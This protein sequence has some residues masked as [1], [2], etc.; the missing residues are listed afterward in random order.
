[1]DCSQIFNLIL[2]S[3]CYQ[4]H[5]N[6]NKTNVGMCMSKREHNL[7]S[8]VI[9]LAFVDWKSPSWPDHLFIFQYGHVH[10]GVAESGSCWPGKVWLNTQNQGL[11]CIEFRQVCCLS[12]FWMSYLT[13]KTLGWLKSYFMYILV[14][15]HIMRDFAYTKVY[16]VS[17]K[18]VHA[19]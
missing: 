15:T 13:G 3:P 19:L 2:N 10:S 4:I 7:L 9:I 14:L 12:A 16:T 1:M 6:K 11:I 5:P 18:W 8:E 17:L